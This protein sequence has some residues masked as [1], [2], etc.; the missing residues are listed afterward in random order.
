VPAKT[1]KK[2]KKIEQ[3][4]KKPPVEP[5]N[6]SVVM[7]TEEMFSLVQILS[8][9]KDIFERMASNCRKDGDAKAGE[10]YTARSLLSVLLYEKFKTVAGIGEP[11]SRDIH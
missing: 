3:P 4:A 6:F 11:E 1:K 9:S 2:T 10:I 7:S 8:F 5:G